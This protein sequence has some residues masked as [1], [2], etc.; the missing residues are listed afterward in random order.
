M[1]SGNSFHKT[2][3]GFLWE[4]FLPK[5]DFFVKKR[6]RKSLEKGT[7]LRRKQQAGRDYVHKNEA[8]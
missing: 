5:F 7:P 8:P 1:F 6:L 4:P 2:P 3:F